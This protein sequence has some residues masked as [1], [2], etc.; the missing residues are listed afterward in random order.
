ML[1]KQLEIED[2]V[3]VLAVGAQPAGANH[4]SLTEIKFPPVKYFFAPAISFGCVLPAGE[5]QPREINVRVC[6]MVC[7]FILLIYIC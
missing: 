1:L 7:I 3:N 6:I 4:S 2:S 5:E